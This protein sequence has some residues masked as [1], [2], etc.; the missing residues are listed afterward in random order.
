MRSNREKV[1]VEGSSVRLCVENVRSINKCPCS[2]VSACVEDSAH[3]N[4][5]KNWLYA[6]GEALN[7]KGKNVQQSH[8]N[9]RRR[10]N[11]MRFR[12]SE[13]QKVGSFLH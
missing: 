11:P 2:I 5:V 13:F 1:E 4:T 7:E 3:H 9:K 10:S 12:N 8:C 6:I